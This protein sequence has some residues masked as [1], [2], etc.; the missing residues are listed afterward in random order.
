M[1][2]LEGLQK[3]TNLLQQIGNQPIEQAQRQ[4]QTGLMQAQTA[5]VTQGDAEKQR[6]IDVMNQAKQKFDSG[7]INGAYSALATVDPSYLDKAPA[8]SDAQ[9]AVKQKYGS[10]PGQVAAT[11][12]NAAQNKP[13]AVTQADGTKAYTT[14]KDLLA[15]NT[16]NLVTPGGQSTTEVGADGQ[17][18]S[19]G[20][21]QNSELL[22]LTKQFN[23]DAKPLTDSINATTDS[24]SLLDKN[25]PGA[26]IAEKLKT[27][28][29]LVQSGR[30][31]QSFVDQ[32]G[33]GKSSGIIANI[34]N[35][36]SEAEGA[37]LGDQARQNMYQLNIALQDQAT[38]EFDA[39][40]ANRS[41]Q[42]SDNLK[43]DPL[44]AKKRFASV[45]PTVYQQIAQ[46]VGKLSP[47]DQAAFNWAHDH[48]AD[49]D[50][51]SASKAKSILSHL[52]PSLGN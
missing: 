3:A 10:T 17:Q 22:K 38:K 11:K 31:P 8:S 36:I 15:G 34:D 21:K 40:L 4:A 28:R 52:A 7:D 48:L 6:R 47:D 27:I 2:T 42:A 23:T 35:A 43:V 12:A 14:Q 51:D 44:V 16:S 26:Q 39:L 32:Y 13:I 33:N 25:I 24:A 19:V 29:G 20:P 50:K 5:D 30:V 18:V 49:K 45:G 9:L 41:Q 46:K 1:P 37:G